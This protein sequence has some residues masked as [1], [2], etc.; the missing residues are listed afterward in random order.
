MLAFAMGGRVAEEVVFDEVSTGAQNDLEKATQIARAMV[1]Q[2]G[3]SDEVG[4]LSLGH[5]DPNSIFAGPKIA[6]G[7]AEKI[8][9]EVMRLLNEAHDRALAILNERRDLLDRLSTLLL[10]TE[11][12]DGPDLEAYA[13]GAK[14]IPT[15][16]EARAELERKASKAAAVAKEKEEKEKP[17]TRTRAAAPPLLPPAP[18]L[19]AD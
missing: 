12:I 2:Y 6:A 7:T 14:A 17:A 8:D 18:P 11:T 3:M 5:D 9:E 10:V 4:P 15:G 19:P 16:D 1:S 13:S